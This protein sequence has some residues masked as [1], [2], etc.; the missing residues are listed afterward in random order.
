MDRTLTKA[1][2]TSTPVSILTTQL[3]DELFDGLFEVIG[4]AQ[5]QGSPAIQG[6]AENLPQ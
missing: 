5:K 6:A 1:A 3:V 2:S 4:R